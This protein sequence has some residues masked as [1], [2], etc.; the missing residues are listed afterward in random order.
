MMRW[1]YF[2]IFRDTEQTLK[3][4]RLHD[5]L[6]ASTSDKEA[7]ATIQSFLFSFCYFFFSP[8]SMRTERMLEWWC[9]QIYINKT[10]GERRQASQ[11]VKMW[12]IEARENA[13]VLKLDGLRASHET[14]AAKIVTESLSIK[15]EVSFITHF[16]GLL[17][18]PCGQPRNCIFTRRYTFW[19]LYLWRKFHGVE[20]GQ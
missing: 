3:S 19:W 15:L 14:Q 1:S 6:L 16:S 4:S 5:S 17:F 11:V 7:T 2:C 13:L 9:N 18:S 10:N 8:N 12:N 20:H